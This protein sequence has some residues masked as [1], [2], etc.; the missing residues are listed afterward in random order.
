LSIGAAV[1]EAR[2]ELLTSLHP[3]AP[4]DDLNIHDT[5]IILPG[6]RAVALK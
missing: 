6:S 2:N 1:T 4:H 3:K 5:K